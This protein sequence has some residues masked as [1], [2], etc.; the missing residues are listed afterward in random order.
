MKHHSALLLANH[1]LSA[2]HRHPK[3][4]RAHK[5]LMARLK[6]GALTESGLRDVLTGL[7]P[8]AQ[9]AAHGLLLSRDRYSGPPLAIDVEAASNPIPKAGIKATVDHWVRLYMDRI[10]LGIYSP[11]EP[12]RG[13]KSSARRH[14]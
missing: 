5:T 10:Q 1:Y 7:V 6:R 8:Y 13:A 11:P 12:R 4:Q 9:E 3:G 2:L 14:R